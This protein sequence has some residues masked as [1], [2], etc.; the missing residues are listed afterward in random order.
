MTVEDSFFNLSNGSQRKRRL[1]TLT[2]GG[3]LTVDNLLTLDGTTS[4]CAAINTNGSFSYQITADT[5]AIQ[6][7]IGSVV[8]RNN[9]I[10]NGSTITLTEDPLSVFAR[11]RECYVPRAARGRRFIPAT[12]RRLL[13]MTGGTADDPNDYYSLGLEGRTEPASKSLAPEHWM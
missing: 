2:L 1:L 10:V 9:L 13:I 4:G 7:G 6:A 3:D 5:I 12:A 11:S 8:H